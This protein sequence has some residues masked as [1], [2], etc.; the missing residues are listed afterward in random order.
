MRGKMKSGTTDDN[1]VLVYAIV[2]IIYVH[3]VGSLLPLNDGFLHLEILE[4]GAS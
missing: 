3:E 2:Y 1:L 4:I